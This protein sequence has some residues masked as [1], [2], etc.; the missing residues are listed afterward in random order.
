[1]VIEQTACQGIASLWFQQN[2][3]KNYRL[4]ESVAKGKWVELQVFD[5]I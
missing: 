3:D 2:E 5:F 4:G 1:V